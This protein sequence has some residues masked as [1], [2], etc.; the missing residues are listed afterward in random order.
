MRRITLLLALVALAS[1]G[2]VAAGCN[3]TEGFG[4][5][6]QSSGRAIKDSARKHND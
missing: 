3:T 4:K 2:V 5:D 6:I 1:F